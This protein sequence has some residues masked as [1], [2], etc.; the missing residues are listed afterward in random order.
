MAQKQTE[1]VEDLQ[2]TALLGSLPTVLH[3]ACGAEVL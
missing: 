1:A 3:C 2:S